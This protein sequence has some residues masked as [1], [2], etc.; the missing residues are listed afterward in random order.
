MRSFSV[1]GVFHQNETTPPQPHRRK[2]PPRAVA[3]T[4]IRHS[5][6]TRLSGRDPNHIPRETIGADI[7]QV[8]SAWGWL[9]VSSAIAGS[10]PHLLPLC[11]PDKLKRAQ[12]IMLSP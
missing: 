6:F 1:G 7:P 10:K 2:L 5:S 8:R 9:F 12:R 3:R 4:P 11:F